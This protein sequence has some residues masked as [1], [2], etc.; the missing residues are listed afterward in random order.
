MPLSPDV[1]RRIDAIVERM[2]RVGERFDIPLT[3]VSEVEVAEA[4]VALGCRIPPEF[5]YM[6]RATL[7]SHLSFNQPFRIPPG[8]GWMRNIV[9]E[10]LRLRS[11]MGLNSKLLAFRYPGTPGAAYCFDLRPWKGNGLCPVSEFQYTGNGK[12]PRI[13]RERFLSVLDW[14]EE[15]VRAAE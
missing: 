4:E 9:E 1:A 13:K 3:P 12:R 6:D 11:E 10:N 7:R 8:H 5:V 2:D 14:L 15:Q